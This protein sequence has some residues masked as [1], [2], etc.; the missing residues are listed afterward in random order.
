VSP[1]DWIGLVIG[2]AFIVPTIRLI[3]AKGW[4]SIAWPLFLVTLPIYYMLFGVLAMDWSIVLKE[5]LYGL[6][7][8]ITGL[9]VWRI[10]SRYTLVVIA[11]AWISHGFYDFYHDIFF[12][13]SGVFSWYPA[14]C[15]FVDIVVGGYILFSY[16]RLADFA[17]THP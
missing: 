4:D 6:P 3:R 8:F 1:D 11:L 9:V 5:F 2:F 10:Q 14:F 7:Y 16:R 12:V 13:N 17:S 15:A